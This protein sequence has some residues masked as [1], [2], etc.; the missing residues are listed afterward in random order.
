MNK[1]N[2]VVLTKCEN[3]SQN[4]RLIHMSRYIEYLAI[5]NDFQDIMDVRYD[6]SDEDINDV[7]AKMEPITTYLNSLAEQH[8]VK[9]LVPPCVI[10][11]IDWSGHLPLIQEYLSSRLTAMKTAFIET[12]WLIDDMELVDALEEIDTINQ[13]FVDE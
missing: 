8:G 11:D 2:T 10:A 5:V 7:I 3:Q 4:A 12:S 9:N 1:H 6:L 13:S